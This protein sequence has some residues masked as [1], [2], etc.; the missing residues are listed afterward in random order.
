MKR[1]YIKPISKIVECTM[2]YHLCTVSDDSGVDKGITGG[3]EGY[4][5]IETDDGTH[6]PTRELR[7]WFED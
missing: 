3:G 1:V 5:P 7:P 2:K 6:A 4:T